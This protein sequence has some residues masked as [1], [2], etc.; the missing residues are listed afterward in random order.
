MKST[1]FSIRVEDELADAGREMAELVG[2]HQ[3]LG[4]NVDKKNK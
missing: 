3:I 1:R 4:A 2:Q